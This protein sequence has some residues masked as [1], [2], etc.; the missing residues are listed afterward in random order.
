MNERRFI[1]QML[2]GTASETEVIFSGQ[3][4]IWSDGLV[5]FRLTYSGPL[6]PSTNN[7][8]AG[9]DHKHELRK[10]FHIQIRRLWQDYPH[11][12]Q[13]QYPPPEH[14][15]V[16]YEPQI[17]K[18][19]D[20]L[21]NQFQRNGYRFV[22]LVTKDLVLSCGLEILYLRRDLPGN[23]VKKG[24]IDSRIKTLF[25]ALKMPTNLQE[26]GK[27]TNPDSD[28]DPFFCLVEDD[29]LI[30]SLSVETD[31]MLEPLST[32]T[33]MTKDDSRLLIT[34]KLRPSQITWSNIGSAPPFII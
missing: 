3:Q 12:Q 25:D 13:M 9:A 27:Y 30:G 20:Y 14:V 21:A 2:K 10:H 17:S 29:S 22:P 4:Q 18:R 24:D 23:I 16:A 32:E 11:L 31:I 6:Y 34:V 7:H 5:E 1:V 15:M 28:E 8:P 33:R 19:I 26:F